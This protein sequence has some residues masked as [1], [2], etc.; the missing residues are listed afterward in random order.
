L[1][2]R[3]QTTAWAEERSDCT[4]TKEK[5]EEEVA[6]AQG[7][8]NAGKR[9]DHLKR[10]KKLLAGRGNV[11]WDQEKKG[12]VVKNGPKVD[13]DWEG[14]GGSITCTFDGRRGRT[15]RKAPPAKEGTQARRRR[16]KKKTMLGNTRN[17]WDPRTNLGGKGKK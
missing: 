11:L 4:T 8:P 3:G 5:R 7:G 12:K 15:E 10:Q 13:R 2:K 16:G 1:K 9:T 6:G 17:C 14:R